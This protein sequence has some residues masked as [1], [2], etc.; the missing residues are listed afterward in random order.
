M[1]CIRRSEPRH[2]A[3]C[4]KTSTCT[5]H[6]NTWPWP[7][8]EIPSRVTDDCQLLRWR[9][10]HV[11][12][13]PSSPW[14]VPGCPS[15]RAA[16]CHLVKH[17]LWPVGLNR[18][19]FNTWRGRHPVVDDC[20]TDGN[21]GKHNILFSILNNFLL[22]YPTNDSAVAQTLSSVETHR[23]QVTWILT[24]ETSQFPRFQ[25]IM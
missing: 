17:D 24:Q 21:C 7:H 12:S 9:C 6:V 22:A 10:K 20:R 8:L 15:I 4:L 3:S 5:G 18:V 13:V 23:G 14:C 11:R 2:G 19:A 16:C 25:L 1:D